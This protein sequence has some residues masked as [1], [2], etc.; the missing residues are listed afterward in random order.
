M[1]LYSE[2][3]SLFSRALSTEVAVLTAGLEAILPFLVW[4]RLFKAFS[5]TLILK[6]VSQSHG[7]SSC[8]IFAKWILLGGSKWFCYFLNTNSLVDSFYHNF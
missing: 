1:A 3:R 6:I 5:V 8:S 4:E 2:N 7:I